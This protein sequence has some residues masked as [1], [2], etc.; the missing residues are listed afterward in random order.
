M[1]QHLLNKEK[2]NLL[3]FLF[4]NI[5]EIVNVYEKSLNTITST[6]FLNNLF[7]TITING[8]HC[9]I[10]CVKCVAKN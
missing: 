9:S 6:Q 4:I 8:T 1:G 3:I 7:L 5:A 2:C 10:L